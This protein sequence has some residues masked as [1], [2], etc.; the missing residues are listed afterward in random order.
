MSK[1][2]SQETILGL[3]VSEKFIRWCEISAEGVLEGDGRFRNNREQ[4]VRHFSR[5][6]V[7]V[8][9][10]VGSHSRWIA[11]ELSALGH[12]VL[13]LDPRRLKLISG[14]VYKDDKLDAERLAVLTRT[15]WRL[16][17]TVQP[18]AEGDQR[19]LSLVRARATLVEMR[20]KAVNAVRGLLKPYGVRIGKTGRSPKFRAE[21]LRV[22]PAELAEILDPMLQSIESLN[23]AITDLD[24]QVED[25]L[26]KLAGDAMHLLEIDGVG[27]L[28]LLYFVALVGDPYRFEKNRTIGS[29]LGL[30]PKR[31]D[32]GDRTSEL[33]ITK[34]GDRYMRALLANC[35]SHILGPFGK[36]CD[37]RRGGLRVAGQSAKRG[38]KKR[39]K[40]AVSRK[41]AVLMLSLWKTGEQYDPDRN[42]PLEKA[43]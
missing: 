23:A 10:E 3:D 1:D 24:R 34:A 21:A 36:D 35:A 41:L 15:S 11:K 28:T 17:K 5:E 9:L 13:V 20:T 42:R 43:A 26:P 18:R 31:D 39:A 6:R 12:E 30:C 7:A 19:A 40:T 38:P 29:Y 16:L 32:S 33:G 22:M 27:A 25:Y 8:A 4:L 14:S 37:L 2:I